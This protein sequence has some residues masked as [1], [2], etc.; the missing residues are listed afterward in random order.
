MKSFIALCATVLTISQIA[1]EEGAS[2]I[3]APAAV[4]GRKLTGAMLGL[5]DHADE[6]F[7][8]TSNLDE[9]L[10][11]VEAEDI[12]AED[13]E[14]EN[15]EEDLD[16]EDIDETDFDDENVDDQDEENLEEEEEGIEDENF[17]DIATEDDENFAEDEDDE[18]IKE[19]DSLDSENFQE[20][21]SEDITDSNI[22][23]GENLFSML[24]EEMNDENFLNFDGDITKKNKWTKNNIRWIRSAISR[25]LRKTEHAYKQGKL[26]RLDYLRVKL[27]LKDLSQTVLH[28][29]RRKCPRHRKHFGPCRSH[30]SVVEVKRLFKESYRHVQK[31]LLKLKN[32]HLTKFIDNRFHPRYTLKGFNARSRSVLVDYFNYFASS[33]G[34]PPVKKLRTRYL[35]EALRGL[36][37][38]AKALHKT[39]NYKAKGTYYFV[40]FYLNKL[41]QFFKEFGLNKHITMDDIEEIYEKARKAVQQEIANSHCPEQ[42]PKCP[43]KWGNKDGKPPKPIKEKTFEQEVLEEFLRQKKKG[44]ARRI[45]LKKKCRHIM[46][47]KRLHHRRYQHYD[48]D[49]Y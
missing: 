4:Q 12:D 6:N 49:D 47:K 1:A 16:V 19:F 9:S 21:G 26:D 18:N 35:V 14:G 42:N 23:F 2:I 36:I 40:N 33:K 27:N 11:E 22:L 29:G 20:A 30:L 32:K 44:G 10:G 24:D 43:G 3:A 48:F 38:L 45:G 8:S 15:L 46:G 17:D 28:H 34:R 31:I 25:L 5:F 39:D 41:Q 7:A 13:L 37:R